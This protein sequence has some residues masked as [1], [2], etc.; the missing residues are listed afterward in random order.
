M[1]KDSVCV[2]SAGIKELPDVDGVCWV[3][4]CVSY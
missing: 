2:L 3:V 4:L 1:V